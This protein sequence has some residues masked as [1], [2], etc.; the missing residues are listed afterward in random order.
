MTLP[1]APEPIL[2]SEE[3]LFSEPKS[4]FGILTKTS[5]GSRWMLHST[6]GAMKEGELGE[7][8]NALP[9]GSV[10][11]G[12]TF[13]DSVTL[14]E[15]HFRFACDQVVGGMDYATLKVIGPLSAK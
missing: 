4:T 1:L 12:E 14:S 13:D 6:R 9:H 3:S 10:R 11:I 7:C 5:P 8:L 15:Y 2:Q